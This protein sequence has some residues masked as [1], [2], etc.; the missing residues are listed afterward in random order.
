MTRIRKEKLYLYNKQISQQNIQWEK[1][2]EE[3]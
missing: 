1:K 2:R 3:K